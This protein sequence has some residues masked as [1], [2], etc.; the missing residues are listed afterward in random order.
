MKILVAVMS[1]HRDRAF[2]QAQRDTWLRG[3][4]TGF[5]EYRFFLGRPSD[6]VQSI[7]EVFLDV[8]DSYDN[9]A[10]KTQAICQWAYERDYDTLFKCDVDTLVNPRKAEYNDE[11]YLGGFNEDTVP[12]FGGHIQFASGGAGYWLSRKALTIVSD[13]DTIRTC[14]EDVFVAD[15]LRAKGIF[16]AFKEGYRWKPG[17]DVDSGMISLHLSSAL[18][19]KYEPE[20]MY[21]YHEKV[22]NG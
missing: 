8:D 19:K 4:N 20:Q 1:C 6:K 10:E 14:A 16:P 12:L 3:V 17:A 22:T 11:D 13:A 5:T 9:L 2:Q 15:A 21:E 7:D 18:Q